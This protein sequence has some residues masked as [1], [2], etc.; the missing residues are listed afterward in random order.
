[1][2]MTK[3][4]LPGCLTLCGRDNE[5]WWVGEREVELVAGVGVRN[6]TR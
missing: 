2:Q 6:G 5:Q 4:V 1:M 3:P